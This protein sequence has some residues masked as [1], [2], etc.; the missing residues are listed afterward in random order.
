MNSHSEI[1]KLLSAYCGDDLTPQDR[2]VVEE[3]LKSCS[4]CRSERA[5]LTKTLELLRST[6]EVEPPLW[7]T[8]RIMAH[9][10]E[11]REQAPGWLKRLFYPLHIKL[12]LEGLAVLLVCVTGFYLSQR[13]GTELQ[14]I[15]QIPAQKR[16]EAPTVPSPARVQSA[17]EKKGDDSPPAKPLRDMNP[18]SVQKT[19]DQPHSI[20]PQ[21]SDADSKP[22]V[23]SSFA[24]APSA[25]KE[26]TEPAAVKGG[27][28]AKDS[29]SPAHKTESLVRTLQSAPTG[30]MPLKLT[31]RMSLTAPSQASSLISDALIHAGASIINEPPSPPGR[32]RAHIPSSRLDELFNQLDKIGKMVERPLYS[33]RSG[34]TEVIIFW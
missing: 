3:H 16:E 30:V 6:P 33:S 34:I 26:R 1:K 9:V 10:H 29:L 19:A 23:P 13:V 8:A 28:A 20:P 18:V 22:A 32:I 4:E 2:L 12:P 24:P 31:I 14:Q 27:D 5:D 7:M 15:Q 25:R 11:Q 21:Q 17:A